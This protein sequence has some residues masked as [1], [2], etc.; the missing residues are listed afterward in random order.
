MKDPNKMNSMLSS[1][2]LAGKSIVVTGGGTG[3]GRSM[4]QMFLQC[5]ANV[6]ITSRKED[7]LNELRAYG[8]AADP[9]SFSDKLSM[10]LQIARK[11]KNR[12]FLTVLNDRGIPIFIDE[13]IGKEIEDTF[14]NKG[15]NNV[16]YQ[17]WVNFIKFK[18]R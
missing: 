16:T 17:G 8:I 10:Q 15:F 12:H 13:A 4:T 9:C 14:R 5:G 18:V 1:T 6:L 7:V 11:V 2:A 3:L